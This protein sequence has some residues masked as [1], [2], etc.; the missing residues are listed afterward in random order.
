MRGVCAGDHVALLGSRR[1]A[2][3]R[4]GALHVHDDGGNL[5]KIRQADKLLHQRDARPG[6]CRES[7]GAVP[8]CA[9][10]DSNRGQ[11]IFALNDRVFR[12]LGLRIVAQFFAMTSE[13]IGER[14]R[15][16]DRIPGADSGA[17]IDRAERRRTVAFDK[18]AIADLVGLFDSKAD[19]ALQVLQRVV[20]SEVQCMDVGGQELFLALVLFTDQLLDQLGI[21]IEQ[22]RERAEVDDVLKQLALA[23]V[24]VS[25]VGDRGQRHAEHRDVISEFRRRHRLRRIIEQIAA[26]LDRGDVLV[27]GL[28][29]HRD[30]HV[31]AA[32]RAQM[33]VL[34]DPDFVPGRQA[35]NIR[36]K[37]I[38]RRNRDAM[39]QDGAGKHLVSARRTRAVDVGK[40]YDEI[41]YAAD[42]AFD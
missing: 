12:L 16:R 40:P 19:R 22:G 20:A 13:S 4:S 11:F 6:C 18:N 38:A 41:V 36:W 2:G 1:H 7:A 28:R 23:R 9:D 34:G 26:G 30:H 25:R 14:R 8:G 10:H 33:S 29:V 24:G 15:W 31:D 27:P 37:D 3:G 17:A 35:L 32:A 39:T 5:R 42:R 21:E